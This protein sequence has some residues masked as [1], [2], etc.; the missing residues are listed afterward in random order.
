MKAHETNAAVLMA[1]GF[2][3]WRSRGVACMTFITSG[4]RLVVTGR[5]ARERRARRGHASD[6]DP[7]R[8]TGHVVEAGA[9]AEGDRAGIT[10][11]LAADPDLEPGLDAAAAAHREL[12]QRA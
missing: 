4:S 11:V 1:G 8:R 7:E 12:D 5:R 3:R 9:M 6:R 2:D 10:A